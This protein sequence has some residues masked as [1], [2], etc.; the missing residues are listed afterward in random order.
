VRQRGD[1]AV[2]GTSGALSGVYQAAGVVSD[3]LVRLGNG[4]NGPC[5]RLV[6]VEAD[7][8]VFLLFTNFAGG[9]GRN[10]LADL[11]R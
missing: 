1:H 6:R 7:K 3:G 8:H 5:V 9:S 10:R 4:T 11:S 2:G